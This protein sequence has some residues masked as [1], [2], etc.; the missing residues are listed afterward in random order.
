MLYK[1]QQFLNHVTPLLSQ[2]LA[3]EFGNLDMDQAKKIL[4]ALET[5]GVKLKTLA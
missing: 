3:I 2:L 4:Q 1:I 5:C